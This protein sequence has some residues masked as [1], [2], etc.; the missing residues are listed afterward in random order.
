MKDTV[1][2]LYARRPEHRM[3]PPVSATDHACFTNL[4]DH[5]FISS[6]RRSQISNRITGC[7]PTF[8]YARLLGVEV[9]L[10]FFKSVQYGVR[11]GFISRL[12]RDM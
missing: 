6:A 12:E 9:K 10:L 8:E 7:F 3:Q 4:S 5:Q 11:G 2:R 1:L